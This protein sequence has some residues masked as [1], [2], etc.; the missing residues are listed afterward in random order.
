MTLAENLDLR[1][2]SAARD[3]EVFHAILTRASDLRA[4]THC[5]LDPNLSLDQVIET[6]IVPCDGYRNRKVLLLHCLR[7]PSSFAPN[8]EVILFV[9][10]TGVRE[11]LRRALEG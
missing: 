8:H 9:C 11:T 2:R 7:G 10:F 4:H 3:A 5:L 6:L 1:V